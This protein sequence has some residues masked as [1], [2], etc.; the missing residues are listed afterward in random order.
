MGITKAVERAIGESIIDNNAKKKKKE[1]AKIAYQQTGKAMKKGKVKK[2][3]GSATYHSIK[4]N[5]DKNVD[6]KTTKRK[7]FLD[8]LLSK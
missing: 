3:K 5:L 2:G 4:S 8:D 1:N 6:N 7:K